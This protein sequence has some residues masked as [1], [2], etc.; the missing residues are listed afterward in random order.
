MLAFDDMMKIQDDLDE[1][2]EYSYLSLGMPADC[3]VTGAP[4]NGE[5]YSWTLTAYREALVKAARDDQT[6]KAAWDELEKSIVASIAKD[7]IVGVRKDRVDLTI[8]DI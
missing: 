7:V 6:K 4:L 2:S 1:M 3:T 8:L 5:M